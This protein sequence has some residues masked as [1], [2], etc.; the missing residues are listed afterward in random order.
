MTPIAPHMTTFLRER[1]PVQRGASVHTCDTYAYAFKLL[2]EFA[3]ERLNVT[4]SGLFLEQLD[5]PLIMDF[6]DH[7][8]SKR[9]NSPST[10]NARLAAIKSFMCFLECRVPSILEQSR[11]ILAI[12]AKRTD[13]K[14]VNHLSITEMQAILNAPTLSSRSGIRDRAM[15]HLCFAAA[16]RVSELVAL[17]F[18]ALT[19]DSTPNIRVLGKGRRERILPLW[20]QTATDL[21]SWIKVRGE[22]P[23]V[24]E[25]FV[26]SRGS[27]MTRSG[28]EYVLGKYTTKAEGACPSLAAKRVSPHVLRHTCA[29]MI[30]QATGDLRKVS[31]WLG[32]A[33]MQTTEMYLRVDPTD[34]LDALKAVVPPN[35]QCG[36]FR[37]PDA[38]I[39]SLLNESR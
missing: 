25:L 24:V 19:L 14:L 20:K 1:L 33:D 27:P 12:P 22:I 3:G 10:R 31:L 2:F 15:L 28:F 11:Q 13:I 32:H 17:P 39:A 9:G 7:L 26:N 37:A 5:A 38:L 8:E 6:L 30:L 4:P 29:A 35:L 16:L 21:R 36:H 23:G 34:K 18:S